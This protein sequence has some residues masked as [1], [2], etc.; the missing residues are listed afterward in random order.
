MASYIVEYT[1]NKIF[2]CVVMFEKDQNQYLLEKRWGL[3][4]LL[5]QF[6]REKKYIDDE[7]DN[8]VEVTEDN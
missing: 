1:L 7:A 4:S 6:G 3:M 2:Y 8:N 5:N